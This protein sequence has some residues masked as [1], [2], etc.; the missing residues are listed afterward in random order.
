MAY[1]Y[2]V[3]LSSSMNGRR[4]AGS[5]ITQQG[6]IRSWVGGTRAR[7]FFFCRRRQIS[8]RERHTQL[9]VQGEA[10]RQEG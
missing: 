6:D 5:C 9:G 8:K 7:P 1:K 10:E 2:S 4:G 3:A